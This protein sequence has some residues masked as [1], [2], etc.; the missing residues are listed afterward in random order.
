MSEDIFFFQKCNQIGLRVV[1]DPQVI[2]RHHKQ[3]NI[4][5]L[6]KG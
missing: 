3:I 1:A 2:C 6:L 5:A 4:T